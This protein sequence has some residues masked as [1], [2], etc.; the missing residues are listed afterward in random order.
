MSRLASLLI[1]SLVC[2]GACHDKHGAAPNTDAGP[3]APPPP[4]DGGEG[5]EP[6]GIG[7]VVVNSDFVSTSI[8]LLD[9]TTGQV[10]N[11]NCINSATRPPGNTLALSGDVVL[12]SQPQ[13]GNL[14]LALDRTNSALTWIDPSTCTPLR[15][16]DVSTGFFSNPHDVIAVSPTKAYVLRYERNETPTPD[17][18][19]HDEGDDLLI[20]DPSVPAITGRI[21]LSSYAVQ[22]TGTNIQARPDRGLQINGKLFVVLS[23]L[24]AD[25]QVGGNGRLLVI[26][27]A[28]DRVTDMIDL[29]EFK[30]CTGLTYAER[31]KILSTAC[32]GVFGEG[33]AAMVAAS[34][35]AYVDTS[36]SPPAEVRH[37]S[38]ALFGGRAVADFS[39]I[40]LGGTLGFGITFGEFSGKPKDQLWAVDVIAGTATKLADSSDSFTFGNVLVD[41]TQEHVYLTDANAAEPRVQIYG[42]ASGVAPMHLTSVNAN[43]AVGLPPRQ[44]AWY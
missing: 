10:T 18:N 26:D 27:P 43:P 8:S 31:T 21:D 44:I 37:Q 13:P 7:L 28:T 41:R 22:V 9:R 6:P 38:A 40:A 39:G 23:N 32:S 4:S 5:I 35:I 11:G 25:F 14:I 29:P 3:D 1:C 36:A 20:I 15:Q 33:A 34:G 19:D 17:P 24:S 12:P 2:L 42:Y 16:L 30:N